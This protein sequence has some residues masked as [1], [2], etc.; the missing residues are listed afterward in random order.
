MQKKPFDMFTRRHATLHA[1][2]KERITAHFMLALVL[3][4]LAATLLSSCS[5]DSPA[6][7]QANKSQQDLANTIR[8]AQNIGVPSSGLKTVLAQQQ[9][10]NGTMAPIALF[11]Q[12]SDINYYRNVTTRY[13]QLKTQT[14][15]IIQVTTEQFDQQAQTDLDGLQHAIA[16]KQ[17]TNVPLTAI[18]QVYNNNQQA[19]QKARYP[20]DYAAIDTNAKNGVST[21]NMMPDTMQRLQTLGQALTLMQQNKQNVTDLQTQYNGDQNALTKAVTPHDLQQINQSVDSLNQ[22]ATTRFKQVIP[23]LAKAKV[24]EFSGDVQQLKKYGMDDSTYQKELSAAQAKLPNVKT[25]QDYEA[26]SSQLDSEMTPLQTDLL[27]GQAT[28]LLQQFHTEVNNWGNTNQY[29]DTYNNQNYPMDE[30]YMPNG[31]GS[32]LDNELDAAQT[33]SD[34]QNALTDIQN[35]TFQLHEMEQNYTDKTP[36]DQP[37]KTDMDLINYYKLNSNQVIVVSFTEEALRLYQ[38]GTLVKSFLITAGR[39]ELPP[40]PGLW[41]PLWRL[42]NTVFKSPYPKGSPYYFP[43]TPINYAILYHQGGYYLHDS[44]WRNDY[45]P[46]T[47]FYHIDSSGNASADYG[48]HG[49][50]NL[51]EAD[52]QWLYNNTSYDTKIVMY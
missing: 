23:L 33:Q 52:A 36:S 35:E 29:H 31:I 24:D 47:E 37:H 22:Q 48:S 2:L 49:C 3:L 32:D 43:D 42:T 4:G 41:T 51:P 30:A 1:T 15:G 34:Y 17:G 45:G 16:A 20:K 21:L 13:Q 9:Q 40:E 25:M 39:P 26:F 38:N 28:T 7:Q 8:Y 10:L 50:V 6:A 27:K 11:D 14:Q 19:M 18:T 46:G 12:Q 44:W 5:S